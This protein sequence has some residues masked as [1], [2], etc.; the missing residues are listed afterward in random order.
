MGEAHPRRIETAAWPEREAYFAAHERYTGFQ[1]QAREVTEQIAREW[2]WDR[3]IWS[4]RLA[5]IDD[6]ALTYWDTRWHGFHPGPHYDGNFPWEAIRRQIQST[7]R[8][9]DLAIWANNVLCGLC[10][11]MA[12]KKKNHVAINFLER[13]HG[14]NPLEGLI[15]PISVECARAYAIILGARLLKLRSPTDGALPTYEALGFQLVNPRKI[16]R[17]C[18]RKV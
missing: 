12:G 4:L 6:R 13:F 5:Q 17:Y 15:A 10:A 7:P 9:F 18:Q 11:G 3:G 8:R 2:A 1:D 14:P 16:V